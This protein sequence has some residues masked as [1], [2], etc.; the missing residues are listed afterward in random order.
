MVKISANLNA[1]VMIRSKAAPEAVVV[2]WPAN[3]MHE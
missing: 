3:A 1:L 2:R